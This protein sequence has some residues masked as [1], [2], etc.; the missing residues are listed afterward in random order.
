M[1]SNELN[2]DENVPTWSRSEPP[3]FP[4]KHPAK[5]NLLHESSAFRSLKF[6][7]FSFSPSPTP[8]PLEM[9]GETPDGNSGNLPS[10]LDSPTT[11]AGFETDQLPHLSHI[12]DNY[13]DED[14]AAVDPRIVHDEPDP[15]EEE[16]GEDLYHDNFLEL[17]LQTAPPHCLLISLKSIATWSTDLMNFALNLVA[18]IGGWTTMTSTSPWASTIL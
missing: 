15:D 12:S 3:H 8:S 9:A 2:K 18:I 14:E 11:S 13:P 5:H 10:E 17:V 4:P 16:E 1:R 7:A 6:R